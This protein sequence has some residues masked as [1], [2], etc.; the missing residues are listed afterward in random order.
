MTGEEYQ[1]YLD[2]DWHRPVEEM[3]VTIS[4]EWDESAAE[5]LRLSCES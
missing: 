3:P 2:T 1:D 5:Q 4:G